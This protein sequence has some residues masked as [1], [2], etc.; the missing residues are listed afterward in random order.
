[1]GM[2]EDES[3]LLGVLRESIAIFSLLVLC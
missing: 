2:E 1:M 3:S